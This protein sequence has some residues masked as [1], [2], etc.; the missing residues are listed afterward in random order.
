MTKQY[1]SKGIIFR[2]RGGNRWTA[3]VPFYDEE[4]CN[5]NSLIG[6]ITSKRSRSI[7]YVL[8]TLLGRS[9]EFNINFKNKTA[10]IDQYS[11]ELPKDWSITLNKELNTVGFNIN[12]GVEN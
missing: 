9:K 10:F 11:E 4:D 6:Y 8:E 5:L 1:W 2:Y 7:T 3:K 12:I